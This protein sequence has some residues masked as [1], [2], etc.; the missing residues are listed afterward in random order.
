MGILDKVKEFMVS[1]NKQIEELPDDVTRDRQLRGLRRQR[2]IQL[3]LR[4]KERLKIQ[5]AAFNK[6]ETRKHLF[7]FKDKKPVNQNMFGV[8]QKKFKKKPTFLGKM[9]L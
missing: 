7:G 9:E 2:R 4:E 8:K 1:R 6:N 3:E 5:I